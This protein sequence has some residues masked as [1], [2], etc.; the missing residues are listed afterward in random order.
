MS[1]I[2]QLEVP[3]NTVPLAWKLLRSLNEDHLLEAGFDEQEIKDFKSFF[4]EVRYHAEN[5]ESCAEYE[6]DE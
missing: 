2:I 4:V 1:E 3:A 6:G 5:N